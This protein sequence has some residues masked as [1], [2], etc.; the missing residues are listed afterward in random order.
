MSCSNY[1]SFV[2]LFPFF[3]YLLP[4]SFSPLLHPL[5]FI[6]LSL[7]WVLS[8]TLTYFPPSPRP[9]LWMLVLWEPGCH[10]SHNTRT[11]AAPFP[12]PSSAGLHVQH[13]KEILPLVTSRSSWCQLHCLPW[14]WAQH[15]GAVDCMRFCCVLYSRPPFACI[16]HSCH[17]SDRKQCV[18]TLEVLKITC[19]EL[20]QWSMKALQGPQFLHMHMNPSVHAHVHPC[21]GGSGFAHGQ[22]SVPPPP[23]CAQGSEICRREAWF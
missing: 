13:P 2:S 3:S 22:S 6:S 10:A 4:L 5:S 14:P 18:C 17:T 9:M 12:L 11:P 15:L 21:R 19:Y 20:L 1:E 7:V 8:P 16:L 23:H